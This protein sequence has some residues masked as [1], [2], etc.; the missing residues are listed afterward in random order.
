MSCEPST[1]VDK[2]NNNK[3][4]N[5]KFE[6][7]IVGA[8]IAGLSFL[9]NLKQSK[10]FKEGKIN[11]RIIEKRKEPGLELGYPIHLSSESRK[12]LEKTLI[13]KDLIKLKK[14]QNKIPIYHDG[15]T[16]SNSNKN[17]QVYKLIREPNKRTMIERKDLLNI[18]K[19]SIIEEE[20]EIEY[21]KE[22][23]ELNQ[24]EN[25]KIEVILKDGERLKVNLLIGA[26][27]MFSSIRKLSSNLNGQPKKQKQDLLENLPWTVINFK[28]SCIQVLKWIKDPYGINTIYGNGFSATLIPLDSNNDNDEE[29]EIDISRNEVEQQIDEEDLRINYETNQPFSNSNKN[30]ID[31]SNE[32]NTSKADTTNTHHE[33]NQPN[34]VYIALTIPSNW[35]IKSKHFINSKFLDDLKKSKEWKDKKEFKLYS[36]KKTFTG[37]FENIILI[38]DSSHG[39]IPF[40][41]SGT[42][43][44]I[45]DSIKLIKILK[46]YFENE[47][48]NDKK[49]NLN[50]LLNEF[51]KNIKKRNDPIIKESKKI[52]WLI[53]GSNQFS[54]LIRFLIFPLLNFKEKL[55]GDRDKI[56][57]ELRNVIE[58]DRQGIH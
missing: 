36:L 18:F 3:I 43:N 28:T 35:D 39:T 37:K 42:G 11:Y 7:L 46:K 2:Q 10:F 4:G 34:S 41:G 24:I 19:N 45:L 12:L 26:D 40:C 57:K 23:I 14:Y 20:K 54:K 1:K 50:F 30:E 8:G 16:I 5:D 31:H 47:N 15:I 44:A 51:K 58:N 56:E 29:D 32:L 38:G 13:K 21:N 25:N 6:I 55:I 17:K 52:L 48:E 53:Q 22:V 27:G 33:L 9:Y 49:N